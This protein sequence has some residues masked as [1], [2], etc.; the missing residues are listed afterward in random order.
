M[1]LIVWFLLHVKEE[2]IGPNKLKVSRIIF[3]AY[4]SWY[5]ER[6]WCKKRVFD[7]GNI[8]AKGRVLT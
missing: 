1:M 8:V 2:S 4:V 6:W 7:E 3:V 5:A